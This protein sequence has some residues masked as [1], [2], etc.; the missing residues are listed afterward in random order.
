MMCY[1]TEEPDT[2]VIDRSEVIK[3]CDITEA[4]AAQDIIGGKMTD[5]ATQ[6]LQ[7]EKVMQIGVAAEAWN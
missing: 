1:L 6:S 4:R 5:E 2:S 7:P 3:D